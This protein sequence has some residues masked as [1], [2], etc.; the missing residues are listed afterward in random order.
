MAGA[1][2]TLLYSPVTLARASIASNQSHSRAP[3]SYSAQCRARP[4]G[5]H[6]S[7]AYSELAHRIW[8]CSWSASA[9]GT[10]ADTD[11]SPSLT[12]RPTKKTTYRD[13]NTALHGLLLPTA[14]LHCRNWFPPPRLTSR[15]PARAKIVQDC[16]NLDCGNLQNES[17]SEQRKRDFPDHFFLEI[18]TKATASDNLVVHWP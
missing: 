1:P 9:H 17:N 13:S 10:S 12:S 6:P 14:D 11:S 8:R 3:P 2:P 15:P 16:E 5:T 18:V 7:S 4:A